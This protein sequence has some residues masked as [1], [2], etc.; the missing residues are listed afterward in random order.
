MLVCTMATF[1]WRAACVFGL[2]AMLCGCGGTSANPFDGDA[3]VQAG[4]LLGTWRGTNIVPNLTGTT[5]WIFEGTAQSGRLRTSF[6]GTTQGCNFTSSGTTAWALTSS[7]Q[8]RVDGYT[9]AVSITGCPQAQNT[10]GAVPAVTAMFVV[11]GS[12]VTFSI[13]DAGNP[14]TLIRVP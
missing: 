3:S 1:S 10:S 4:S 13:A 8:I 12:A 14:I 9:T 5:T 6:E 2:H 7:D 11:S